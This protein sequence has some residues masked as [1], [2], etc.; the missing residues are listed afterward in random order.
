MNFYTDGSSDNSKGK[1]SRAGCACVAEDGREWAVPCLGTSNMAELHA[2]ALAL[3][4]CKDGDT[5][6][7]DS[8]YCVKIANWVHIAKANLEMWTKVRKLMNERPNTAI[9][10]VRGHGTCEHNRRAD[11]L[12]RAV[13]LDPTQ[14]TWAEGIPEG[15]A[16]DK[17]VSRIMEDLDG[18]A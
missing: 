16:G 9:V 11:K 7:S 8:Q 5:I 2:L 14:A 12:A 1:L 17:I 10:W 18:S 4:Y 6:Y 3:R 13:M 15:E